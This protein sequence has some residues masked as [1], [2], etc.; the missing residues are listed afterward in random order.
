M[1]GRRKDVVP[2]TNRRKDVVRKGVYA[3]AFAECRAEIE[4]FTGCM[5]GRMFSVVYAC[6]DQNRAMNECLHKLCVGRR[7]RARARR[8]RR[9]LTKRATV[10]RRAYACLLPPSSTNPECMDKAYAAEERRLA[11][12]RMADKEAKGAAD[13]R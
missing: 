2:L 10:L 3:H 5:E 9:A 11:E 1:E 4:T 12:K 8:M 13:A 6:R 7:A